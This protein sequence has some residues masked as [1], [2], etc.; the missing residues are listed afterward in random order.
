MQKKSSNL[1][2]CCSLLVL[3]LTKLSLKVI[4]RILKVGNVSYLAVKVSA[5]TLKVVLQ[6]VNALFFTLELYTGRKLFHNDVRKILNWKIANAKISIPV[7]VYL[8]RRK[9]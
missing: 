6:L 9:K 7:Y 2:D 5:V 8:K 4:Q 1:V 3:G